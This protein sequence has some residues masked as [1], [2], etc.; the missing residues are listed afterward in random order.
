MENNAFANECSL[1]I[2]EL[3]R[4]VREKLENG[5]PLIWVSGEISNFTAAASGHL[6]FSLK[7][8]SAQV[9]CVVWRNKAQLLGW[10]PQNGHQVV[11]RA[12]V[13]LYEPR[14]DFQLNVETIRRAGQGE[15]YQRFMALKARLESEGLFDT[16]GKR[17]LPIFPRRIGI[18]TSPQAAALR[19]VLTTLQR[20][21]P[22]IVLTLY[23]TPVQGEGAALQIT[24]ALT[25]AAADPNDVLILCRGGGS[26]EDLWAFNEEIVARA[27]RAS[28]IPVISGIGHETDF[29]IADF[30]ADLR[31]PTPTAAAE[32]AAPERSVLIEH[33]NRL[34]LQLHNRLWRNLMEVSQRLDWLESRL[35]HPRQQLL[36]QQQL[37]KQFQTRLS[38]ALA[39]RYGH[40]QHR[41]QTLKLRFSHATANNLDR[42]S[43]RLDSLAASFQQLN[44]LSIL[45]R[46]YAVVQST[47]G[48]V[49]HSAQQVKPGQNVQI[50]LADGRIHAKAI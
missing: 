5:F 37:I 1:T 45:K 30:A 48:S 42:C 35:L 2:S 9:R 16:A 12:L 40:C 28:P 44:P 38:D 26:I 32:L 29:T 10:R 8:Q 46:G 41:L 24:Q 11:V 23:S 6:Y 3:N 39:R 31:A 50:I 47:D 14:G 20:R 19:D 17:P 36:R 15:L 4:R 22:H 18:V 25:R 13:T 21:A 7:D 34:H 33:L 43:R 27:L 49:I